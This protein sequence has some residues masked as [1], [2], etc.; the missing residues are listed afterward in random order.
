MHGFRIKRLPHL[1]LAL[2]L[3]AGFLSNI[4]MASADAAM[5]YEPSFLRQADRA[6]LR[7]DPNRALEIVEAHRDD[8]LRGR[9]RASALG[10]ACRANLALYRH[11]AAKSACVAA[12]Q[13]DTSR[14]NWRYFNNLG[15]AEL[16]LGNR[17]AAHDAFL[18]AAS[19]SGYAREPRINLSLIEAMDSDQSGL[20]SDQVATNRR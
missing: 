10:L 9:Y 15:V 12:I 14:K 8:Q 16:G 7:G 4:P 1:A 2:F 5:H 20:G 13:L 3:A 18:Q 6:L 17:S 11:E 19:R